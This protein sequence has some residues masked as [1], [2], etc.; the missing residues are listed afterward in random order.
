MKTKTTFLSTTVAP[1]TC[2]ERALDIRDNDLLLLSSHSATSRSSKAFHCATIDVTAHRFPFC[3]VW[4]P[5]PILTWFL[6]FIGHLGI[7]DSKGVIFDFAGPYT[8][9]RNAFAFGAPTRYLQCQVE[10]EDVFKWDKAVAAGCE[11]YEKRM[12][13]L[14]CDNCHSHVAVCLEHAHY[15]GRKKWNMV[16]LCLWMFLRGKYV[17]TTGFIKTWLPFVF[18]LAMVAIMRSSVSGN[19]IPTVFQNLREEMQDH[20]SFHPLSEMLG[21]ALSR[22]QAQVEINNAH[23][24][25]RLSLFPASLLLA[26]TNV[27]TEAENEEDENDGIDFR[28]LRAELD[29]LLDE[30]LNESDNGEIDEPQDDD[31]I[32]VYYPIYRPSSKIKIF[33]AD[34]MS[35]SL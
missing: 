2:D 28:R 13:N 20:F 31:T 4:S 15:G 22:Y 24:H 17:S 5:I 11:I 33:R 29:R 9:G 8:I 19:S 25:R 26:E 16:Q 7:A 14:C 27:M 21:Y 30:D 35:R 1:S 3:L 10:A 32:D 12:H 6:P 23:N 18:V 34:R